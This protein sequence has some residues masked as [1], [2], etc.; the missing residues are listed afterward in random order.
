MEEILSGR[1]GRY[2][3][4]IKPAS[5]PVMLGTAIVVG[6]G[7]GLL[8]V[9]F[10]NLILL[11]STFTLWFMDTVGLVLGLLLAMGAAGLIVGLLS[12][13]WAPEAKGGGIPEVMEAVAIRR[14][15][16]PART[17]LTKMVASALTIGTGGSAG[18]EGPI[19][20]IGAA[21]GSSVGKISRFSSEQQRT[22][23]ACGA[24]AGISAAFNAPIAGSIFALEVVLGKLTVSYFSSVVISA[25]SAAIVGRVFLGDLPAFEVPIYSFQIQEWFLY[26]IL[27]LLSGLLA[28]F[29]VRSL[30][31]SEKAFERLHLPPPLT[32]ALG[33]VLT[34]LVILVTPGRVVAG[35]S[36][37]FT[38]QSLAGD[39]DVSIWMLAGLMVA[40]IVATNLTLGS[41]NAGGVF[42]PLLFIG[43]L[44]G[45]IFG[46]L[47]HAWWPDI[48]LFPQAYAIVGMAAVFAAATR[49]PITA[50]LIIF[51][52]SN[53]YKLI[54]PLMLAS[55]IA[56]VLAEY[57]FPESIYTLKL[58]KK[59]IHLRHG[60][61]YDLMHG[62][63]VQEVMTPEPFVV[64]CDMPVQELRESFQ[65]TNS[66][67]FP[68][69]D[70]EGNLAGVVS[71]RDY[72]EGLK[73][74]G[75]ENLRVRDIATMDRILLAY[76]EEPVSDALERMATW[77][78]SRMPVVAKDA[79]GRITGL[80]RRGDIIKAYKLAL[81]RQEEGQIDDSRLKLKRT[82]KMKFVEI[83]IHPNSP[84][85]GQ[86]VADIAPELPYDCVIVSIRRH[87]TL[88]I[89]HGDTKINPEDVITFFVRSA[90]EERLQACF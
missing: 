66:H 52:M 75:A 35:S 90:D 57:L 46:S 67:G 53:D 24:A 23:V 65:R 69:I 39:L 12:Q 51:E 27:G 11:V 22:I 59:G 18:R 5:F 80:I 64:S 13:R 10:V 45:L 2:T 61:D 38:G 43:S 89:P 1:I 42:S 88:L 3:R 31:W 79:P 8:A 87:G 44:A 54:L 82:D 32:A 84:V 33:M 68:V 14:G 83:R 63:T 62:V 36:L 50:V 30:G 6:I 73:R 20:Q 17:I 34:G 28:V 19:V 85:L 9:L 49:A 76:E 40:K 55:V 15:H 72:Q 21:F 71:L 81:S 25:V 29:I 26:V 41:G 74:K 37:A 7:T 16:I 4:R 77:D 78:V 56:T 70:A 47:V 48:A 58:R 60:R 86:Y